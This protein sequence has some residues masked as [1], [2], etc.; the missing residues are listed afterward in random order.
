[1]FAIVPVLLGLVGSAYV[2][3]LAQLALITVTLCAAL[4]LLTGTAG[5]L[6]LDATVFYGLGAYVAAIASV[7]FG[8]GFPYTLLLAMG[9]ATAIGVVIGFALVRLV[10]I[11]FAVATMGLAISFNT[12][13]LNWSDVTQGP[14]GYRGIPALDFFGL[15]LGENLGPY[16][17]TAGYACV[18]LWVVHRCM[19]SFYGNALRAVREDEE[20]A[21]SMGL[22]PRLLKAQ[23]YAL[24]ACLIGGAGAL[25]AHINQFIGP[26][27]F[28]LLESALI[29]TGIVVG[30]LGSWP[31]AI[32]G[33]LLMALLPEMLREFG[34]F[35]IMMLGLIL[36]FA[37]L[38]LPRGL[39][40]EVRALALVRRLLPNTTWSRRQ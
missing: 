14:M 26:D 25:Y 33:G 21:R 17:V 24:H 35:R 7:Q 6:A 34:H 23:A 22:S 1:V 10:S 16:F 11:F 30:G 3:R 39:Y 40:S 13:V 19:H 18:V 27:N 15:P 38:L 29:L 32:I 36:F 31:G 9:V 28:V 20:C 4:N 37:I 2:A 12:I 5:L 8:I